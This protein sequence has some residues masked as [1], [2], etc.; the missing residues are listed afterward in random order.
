[1]VQLAGEDEPV[2]RDLG[3]GLLVTYLVDAGEA[4]EYIQGRH[5]H[6]AGITPDTLHRTAIDNLY[7]LAERH[8]QVQPFGSI[9]A[10]FMEG[11]FEASVL[12]LDTVWDHSLADRARG[13]FL[14]VVPSRDVLAF[15]DASSASTRIELEAVVQRVVAGNADHLLSTSFYRRTGSAWEPA[16]A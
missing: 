2:L 7:T 13:G 9:Y 8:L 16:D 1:V 12:L 4:F 15:G 5:L 14:A 10:V 6:A 3:N 11:H